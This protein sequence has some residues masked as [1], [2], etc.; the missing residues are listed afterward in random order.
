MAKFKVWLAYEKIYSAEAEIEA[1]TQEEA[2]QIALKIANENTGE[3]AFDVADE[4]AYYI[5]N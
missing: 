4:S 3:F 5:N 1:E 2:N